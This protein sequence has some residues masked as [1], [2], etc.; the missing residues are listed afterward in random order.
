VA[1]VDEI[2]ADSPYRYYRLGDATTTAVD[3]GSDGTDG[4]HSAGVTLGVTGLVGDDDDAVSY[5]GSSGY[6]SFLKLG[7]SV[8]FDMG[9]HD[10]TIMVA[11]VAPALAG[12]G[13]ENALCGDYDTISTNTGTTVFIEELSSQLRLR[14]FTACTFS[15]TAIYNSDYGALTPGATYLLHLVW[16]TTARSWVCYLN[17]SAITWNSATPGSFFPSVSLGDPFYI[18]A[19]YDPGSEKYFT[20]VMDEFALW[21]SKLTSTRIAAHAAAVVS[22]PDMGAASLPMSLS[23]FISHDAASLPMQLAGQTAYAAAS[24][25]MLLESPAATHYQAGVATWAPLVVLDGTDIT[26]QITG[27]V[28]I[29]Q[30][31]TASALCNLQ[32]LPGSGAIDPED[33]ER[34]QLEVSFVGKSGGST[35]YTRRRFTGITT[36]AS[37]NPDTGVLSIKGTTDLQGR[38]ENLSRDMI[39]AIVGGQW[40]KHIFEESADGWQYAKDRLSTQAAELHVDEYGHLRV[41]PWAAKAAPDVTFTDAGR[42]NNSLSLT[43]VNR[44]ELITDFTVNLDFRFVRLRHREIGVYLPDAYG[45]CHYLNNGW[46][47][48]PRSVVASAADSTAWTRIGEI[49]F[50]PLPGPGTYCVPARGWNGEAQDFCLGASWKAARRWAQ[51]VTEE[52]TLTVTAPD[53]S[54]TI[55]VQALSE[56]YGIET[57]YDATDYEADTSFADVPE[58]ASLSVET[59]DYQLEATD[60]EEDGR[61]AM[62]AAQEVV[63]AKVK[64]EII[65]RARRNRLS[66]SPVYD[67]TITLASTVRVNTPYLVAKGKVFGI[68]ETWNTETGALD[69]DLTLAL[70]RHGGS[71]VAVDS[72]LDAADQ[73]AQA[74]EDATDRVYVMGYHIGGLTTVPDNEE[75]DGWITNA[76]EAVHVPGGEIYRTRMVVNMPEIEEAAR[77]ATVLQQPASYTLAIPEDELT[78]SN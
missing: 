36:N 49:T 13:T 15:D 44:R 66:V 51:T 65:G 73:P 54:E 2:L 28:R 33:Y 26:S 5:N 64:A 45:F 21:R 59:N 11:F 31:E 39:D 74:T 46:S 67:P 56:D 23:G 10:A 32:L 8:N 69:M 30:E 14:V 22:G 12:N 24:L 61:A 18:G 76:A 57:T 43:R 72:P 1:F 19:V 52:Y 25:P 55:G 29:Q 20:G 35:L 42:F 63:L 37:Y 50:I 58:G 38:F 60:V 40:S 71:G 62:E 53:L 77:D 34:K 4:T 41:I 16:D 6:T 68:I 47:L 75:W 78:L 3:D 48:P 70:S 17:G 7:T 9:S 27:T